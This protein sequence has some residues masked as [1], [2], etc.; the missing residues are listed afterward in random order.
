[1]DVI[2]KYELNAFGSPVW[3]PVGAEVISAGRKGSGLFIW[4]IVDA[5][6]KGTEQ[7]SFAIYGTG[8]EMKVNVDH[9]FIQTIM[10]DDFVFHVFEVKGE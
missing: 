1:M 7:R 2:Y 4:A 3:L 6:E 5:E 10:F 9:F 8:H